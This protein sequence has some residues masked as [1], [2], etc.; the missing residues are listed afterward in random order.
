MA[1]ATRTNTQIIKGGQLMLFIGNQTVAFATSHSLSVTMN[2]VEINTK[3]HGDYNHILPTT[4]TWEISTENLFSTDGGNTL[5]NAILNKT[6]LTV[7][8][9][10]SDYAGYASANDEKGIVD[11]A[12]GNDEWTAATNFVTGKAYVTSLTVN[13]NQGENATFS[14]TFTGTGRLTVPA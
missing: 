1:A 4:V 12:N 8:F 14:A 9:A 6:Q 5:R 11:S 2:T 7:A 10:L 3:D 13:A